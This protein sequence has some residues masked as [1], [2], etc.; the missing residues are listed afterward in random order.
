MKRRWILLGIG[1]GAAGVGLVMSSVQVDNVCRSAFVE[2]SRY[3]V[4][5]HEKIHNTEIG[6]RSSSTL[7]L[8]KGELHLRFQENFSWKFWDRKFFLE[9]RIVPLKAH[10]DGQTFQ[11]FKGYDA[12]FQAAL[13]SDCSLKD[14]VYDGR[15][16]FAVRKK[17]QRMMSFLAL[18]LRTRIGGHDQ[19]VFMDQWG[20]STLAVVETSATETRI[21]RTLIELIKGTDLAA[22]IRQIDILRSDFHIAGREG[23]TLPDRVQIQESLLF[24]ENVGQHTLDYEIKLGRQR[25]GSGSALADWEPG[26]YPERF[27]VKKYPGEGFRGKD[28]SSVYADIPAAKSDLSYTA[29]LEGFLDELERD[30]VL[31]KQRLIG[32]LLAHPEAL[33][34]LRDQIAAQAFSDFE[35][36][37]ILFAIAKTGSAE[38]QM[39]LSTL[40]RDDSLDVSTRL[41][42]LFALPEVPFIHDN[43]VE[44]VR[45]HA[46][47]LAD[48]K[49]ASND[50]S[51]TS[52]LISGVLARNATEVIP[53]VEER[54]VQDIEEV[55]TK[56]P[57]PHV[58]ANAIDALGN[59][60]QLAFAETIENYTQSPHEA[61]R[62]AA[63]EALAQIPSERRE[64]VLLQN[65]RG[66]TSPL[67]RTATLNSLRS[68]GIQQPNSFAPL[69]DV[70]AGDQDAN[71]RVLAVDVLGQ[72]LKKLP[73][74]RKI[75][76][77]HVQ[78][79]TDP[80]VLQTIGRYLNAYELA[81][82]RR[83]S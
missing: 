42:V 73:E 53:H 26:K 58:R 56:H 82:A 44:A 74:G 83:K 20:R 18:A 8:F 11:K 38:A 77:E 12:S 6:S 65:L 59:Y 2:P 17:A 21:Q 51:S 79:E 3:Q 32:Y 30:A 54:L 39:V 46:R 52:L 40:I 62:V 41:R 49:S 78:M 72:A 7:S 25:D 57:D 36:V 16:S 63:V 64:S 37:H 9:G 66:E 50:M 75:L 23:M 31:A 61:E 81:D 4:E 67:V 13:G 76:R 35:L 24:R 55:L 1:A 34:Q 10:V 43:L 68:I 47:E 19:E 80:K 5:I 27:A 14:I 33:A 70:L 15:Q 60:G 29:F 69:R 45:S 48:P 28:R 71:H 22:E